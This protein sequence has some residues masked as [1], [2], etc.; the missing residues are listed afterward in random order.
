MSKRQFSHGS[1]L[2]LRLI[3]LKPFKSIE[4]FKNL[5]ETIASCMSRYAWSCVLYFTSCSDCKF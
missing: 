5:P 2:I 4:G 1:W 3:R